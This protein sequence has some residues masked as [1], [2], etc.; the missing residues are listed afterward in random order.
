M[1]S[2]FQK[3]GLRYL[4]THPWQTFLS[5]LGIMLGVAV[6]LSI[7]IANESSSKAFDI[8]MESVTGRSTHRLSNKQGD[9]ALDTYIKLGAEAGIKISAPVIEENVK[10]LNGAGFTATFLGLDPFSDGEFRNF[11]SADFEGE[12]AELAQL[13]SSSNKVLIPESFARVAMIN[14]G[15]TITLKWGE[16]VIRVIC[17][18]I[19]KSNEDFSGDRIEQFIIS[20]IETA[21]KLF[22]K[23]NFVS[24]IDLILTP[25]EVDRIEK[26]ISTDATLQLSKTEKS[27]ETAKSM[28]EAFRLNL[29][30]MSL[31]ALIVGL[32]LIYNAMTFSVV[33]RRRLL[34]LLR[35]AG[36]TRK[37][38]FIQVMAESIFIASLGTIGGIV[39]GIFLGKIMLGYVTQSL[40]D[41]YFV[42]TVKT[43]SLSPLIIIKAGIAGVGGTIIAAMFP[44]YEAALTSPGI[45]LK[46]SSV[47]TKIKTKILLFSIISLT[48]LIAAVFILSLDGSG[49]LTGYFGIFLLILA[50]ALQTPA[51]ITA[52]V[53]IIEP[54]AKK[55]LGNTGKIGVRSITANMSRTSVAIAALA[56]SVSATIGVSTMISSFR[57]TVIDWLEQTLVADIFVSSQGLV[58][59][60]N[61]AVLD[62]SLIQKFLMIDGVKTLDFYSEG[63]GTING[64]EV[65][66]FG[67]HIHPANEMRFNLKEGNPSTAWEEIR[68]GTGVLM[69][70]TFAY[71]WNYKVGDQISLVTPQ[72]SLLLKVSAIYYDYSSDLGHIA[73]EYDHFKKYWSN[74]KISGIGVYLDK[75]VDI[76]TVQKKLRSIFSEESSVSIRLNKDLRD[77][78]IEIFDRTFIIA[79]L[80]HILSVIV[81]FIGV[82]SALMSIQLEKEKEMGILRATGLTPGQMLK[83]I[84]VQT[85]TIGLIAAL[86]AIPLGLV[87]AYCLIYIINLRSF[88]WTMQMSIDPV[89]LAQAIIIAV[90][91]SLLAGLYPARKMSVTLPSKSLRDE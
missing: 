4:F 61:E 30:A 47:E 28:T 6:I 27:N 51:V 19:I 43:V 70:E 11:V 85:F 13:L 34:A 33:Q 91:A 86:I 52:F 78:S 26:T 55:V 72:G 41:L 7:D 65:E 3:A 58:S 87:L 21:R 81:A 89:V 83:M 20:D 90:S 42:T 37:D 35:A 29:N 69:T 80:L 49:I 66:V 25:A 67:S 63:S 44:A 17:T 76:S 16:G 56:I 8:S 68:R 5:S 71:K 74:N 84:S 18:G 59:R 64:K 24:Y 53:K 73:F 75:D 9:I 10:V 32:F 1:I 82:F 45:S 50:F 31:L 14:A 48:L 77:Y 22:N 23:G 2:L 54:L 46:R 12:N 62:T 40:N 38:I 60:K 79:G 36:V 39:G 88:G 15:D 57:G